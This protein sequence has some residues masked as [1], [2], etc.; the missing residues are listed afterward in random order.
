M[1]R[2]TF[3]LGENI[4]NHI[5]EE[6]LLSKHTKNSQNSTVRKNSIQTIQSKNEQKTWI[7]TSPNKIYR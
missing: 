2:A 4:C 1:I 6:R 7:E 3:W 5:S